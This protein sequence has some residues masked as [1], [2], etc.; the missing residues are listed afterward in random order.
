MKQAFKQGFL[1]LH[2]RLLHIPGLYL[3]VTV[4]VL[5][6]AFSCGKS[7]EQEGRVGREEEEGRGTS[8]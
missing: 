6:V 4:L 1:S 2:S 3:M 8:M 5:G 7:E